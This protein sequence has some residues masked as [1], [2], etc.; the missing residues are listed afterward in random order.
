MT[1]PPTHPVGLKVDTAPVF[2]EINTDFICP[3][4]KPNFSPRVRGYDSKKYS[5]IERVNKCML[6]RQEA[7]VKFNEYCD[8]Q[9]SLDEIY[10]DGPK[11]N[12]HFQNGE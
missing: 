7:H 2:A 3:L 9:W 4:N 12:H 8:T 5:P 10:T 11:I 6:P 1:Q